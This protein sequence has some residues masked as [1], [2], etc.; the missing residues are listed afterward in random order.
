MRR[1]PALRGALLRAGNGSVTERA[2][3]GSLL[4]GESGEKQGRR[5]DRESA[6][7]ANRDL[8]ELPSGS[9][10]VF[11]PGRAWR[12]HGDH[13][14]RPAPSIGDHPE[15]SAGQLAFGLQ[16]RVPLV[17][18]LVGALPQLLAGTRWQSLVTWGPCPPAF[19]SWA[20]QPRQVPRRCWRGSTAGQGSRRLSQ[21]KAVYSPRSG[22]SV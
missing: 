16:L 17:V 8:R 7:C 21:A 1:S 5:L 22:V 12:S 10:R 11:S 18:W 15:R 9:A 3:G 4:K 19:Q 14:C 6:S 20:V 2:A 13:A